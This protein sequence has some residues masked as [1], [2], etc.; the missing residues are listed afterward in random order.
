MILSHTTKAYKKIREVRD[1]KRRRAIRKYWTS[2]LP[3]TRRDID[4]GFQSDNGKVNQ[5]SRDGLRPAS[6]T[7]RFLRNFAGPPSESVLEADE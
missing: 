6:A 3:H 2:L 4:D 7:V 1:A 5:G